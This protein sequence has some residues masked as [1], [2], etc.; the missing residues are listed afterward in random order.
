MKSF[1]IKVRNILADVLS[2]LSEPSRRRSSEVG[3]VCSALVPPVMS[4]VICCVKIKALI[5]TESRFPA[6]R[7][8]SA[9]SPRQ[10]ERSAARSVCPAAV[11]AIIHVQLSEFM[12]VLGSSQLRLRI[13]CERRRLSEGAAVPT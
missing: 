12:D 3:C 7:S 5:L 4:R 11:G 8:Q 1:V 13:A 10:D 6:S 2:A 9:G